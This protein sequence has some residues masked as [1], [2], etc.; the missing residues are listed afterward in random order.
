ML[1]VSPDR[2][3]EMRILIVLS[4]DIIARYSF[5]GSGTTIRSP[6]SFTSPLIAISRKTSISRWGLG[7][8]DLAEVWNEYRPDELDEDCGALLMTLS[9]FTSPTL[10][11]AYHQKTKEEGIWNSLLN[12]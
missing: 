7:Y 1:L 8:D 9:F 2:C 3:T 12:R 5:Q 10:A 4:S 11:E 6:P